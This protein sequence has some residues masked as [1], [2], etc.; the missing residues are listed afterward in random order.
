MARLGFIPGWGGTHRLTRRI[1][2]S[3]AKFFFYSGKMLDAQEAKEIGL[4]DL[5]AN[6]GELENEL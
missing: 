3:K 4:I 5:A 1:G 6:E 2:V